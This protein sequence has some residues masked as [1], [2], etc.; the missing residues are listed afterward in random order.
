MPCY[1]VG[2]F[3][4]SMGL[5]FQYRPTCKFQEQ[6]DDFSLGEQQQQPHQVVTDVAVSVVQQLCMQ[7]SNVARIS[8]MCARCIPGHR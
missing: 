2:G 1:L 7:M 6:P 8:S 4:C 3:L 5:D